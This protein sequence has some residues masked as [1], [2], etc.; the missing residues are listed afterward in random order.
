V[1][2]E[3]TQRFRKIHMKIQSLFISIHQALYLGPIVPSPFAL[4]CP[5]KASIS[6]GTGTDGSL[7]RLHAVQPYSLMH[8]APWE[9]FVDVQ[10][11]SEDQSVGLGRDSQQ[12]GQ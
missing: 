12:I 1:S 4:P 5:F 7:M 11:S 10:S 3:Q 2:A 8:S 9:M 6:C